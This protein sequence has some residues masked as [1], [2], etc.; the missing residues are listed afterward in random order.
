M[1]TS[2]QMERYQWILPIIGKRLTYSETLKVCPHGR[3]SLERWVSA[4]KKHGVQ[5]LIPKSTR[6][7]TQPN[8]TPIRIKEEVITLRKQT[9]LC[10]LKLHWKLKKQGLVVPHSTVSKI[11][12]DEGLV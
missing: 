3:R 11:L 10:A 4:Y 2:I 6:P 12:K 5:G 9:G 7:K 1:N 8:E